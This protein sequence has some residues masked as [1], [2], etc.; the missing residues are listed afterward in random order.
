MYV[1]AHN[2]SYPSLNKIDHGDKITRKPEKINSCSARRTTSR[3]QSH[4]F[5]CQGRSRTRSG[6]QQQDGNSNGDDNGNK[7]KR[8]KEN[9]NENQDNNKK[10]RN[11]QRE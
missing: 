7:P 8:R 10:R 6:T 4:K 3:K 5:S 1:N 2:N 9:E 11:D